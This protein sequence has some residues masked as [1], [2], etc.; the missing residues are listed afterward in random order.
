MFLMSDMMYER[1]HFVVKCFID[2]P[3]RPIPQIT[4]LNNF[5]T[6]LY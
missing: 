4:L 5:M 3:G 2:N 1:S 6:E